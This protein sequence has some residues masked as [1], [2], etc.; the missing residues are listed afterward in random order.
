MSAGTPIILERESVNDESVTLVRWCVDSGVRVEM[1]ALLAEVET[2]KANM[3]VYSP[4]AGMLVHSFKA[5]TEV[6]IDSAI[7]YIVADSIA[8]EKLLDAE[9]G[10]P[11]QSVPAPLELTSNL[12]SVTVPYS[13]S[14]ADTNVR[15][16]SAS[17][18]KQRISPVAAKMMQEHGLTAAQ[19]SSKSIVRKRDVL[20]YLSPPAPA[21]PEGNAVAP[22]P[23][24]TPITQPYRV[25]ALS[26]MKRREGKNLFAGVGNAVSSATSV[27][28][29]TRGLRRLLESKLPGGASAIITFEVSRLLRKYR[30]FNATYRNGEMLEYEEV[31]LGYAMDDGRGLKV[32]VLHRCDEMSLQ[33]IS[34][35]LRELTIAY[36]QDK[37]TSAQIANPTFTV[38]DMSGAGAFSFVPLIAEN[39]A[40]ILGVGAEHYAPG[41]SLGC[42]VLTLSFDH[43]LSD[44]RTAAHFLGDLKER[45]SSYEE[46]VNDFGAGR[47]CS[48]CGRMASDLEKSNQFLLHSAHPDGF[49]CTL[50]IAGY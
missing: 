34:N 8:G 24:L 29:F 35:H 18:F 46:S 1:G 38:S 26:K 14:K 12:T 30:A 41:T 28:C 49:I 11:E 31:N 13:Q 42:Y 43:Q 22:K 33:E 15:I 45:L 21:A 48:R 9:I 50:C 17:G 27:V 4:S 40:A 32:A 25:I 39:Q 47:V 6:P 3:E 44:G 20:D 2:S 10:T 37:L 36:L 23:E 16:T 19:F 7:G 5:G